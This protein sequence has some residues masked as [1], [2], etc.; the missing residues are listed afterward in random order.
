LVGLNETLVLFVYRSSVQ[1]PR[2]C[3]GPFFCVIARM[4]SVAICLSL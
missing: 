3:R 4:E 2:R 1:P